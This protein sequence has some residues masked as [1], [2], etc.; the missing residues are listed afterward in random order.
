MNFLAHLLLVE[1][2]PAARLG[3]LLPDLHRG[4]LPA[5]LPPDVL[6]GVACHRRVDAFTDRHPAFIRTCDRLQPFCGRYRSI[7]ADVLYDHCLS[8]TWN[9]YHTQPR[10]AFIAACHRDLIQ[11]R[12]WTTPDTRVIV[13]RLIRQD[14]LSTY[15][16]P[17]GIRLTLGGMSQRLTERL[18]RPVDLQGGA[19]FLLQ[20]PAELVEDFACF[21]PQVIEHLKRS[22]EP[23]EAFGP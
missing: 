2:T 9:R 7:V 20:Q 11:A 15:A 13:D 17:E 1:A 16:T 12:Q 5:D 14:W 6:V 3:S 4:R 8:V 18:Q 10:Q 22:A 21:F 19:D 23:R